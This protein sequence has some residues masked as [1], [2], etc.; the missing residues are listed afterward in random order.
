MGI[1]EAFVVTEEIQK[2]ILERATSLT[3]QKMAQSQGMI[4]M[5]EDGYLKVLDGMTTL[6]EI[7]R[8]AAA[9]NT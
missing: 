2:L 8:V 6:N 1:Y 9:D 4:T 5:R 7:N 3:I